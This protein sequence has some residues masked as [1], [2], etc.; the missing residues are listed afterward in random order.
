MQVIRTVKQGY[1]RPPTSSVSTVI[2]AGNVMAVTTQSKQTNNI[3]GLRQGNELY[4]CDPST[5]ELVAYKPYTSRADDMSVV[6]A[7][8]KT[9]RYIIIANFHGLPSEVEVV[10]TYSKEY[11]PAPSD[12]YYDYKNFYKRLSRQHSGL[13]YIVVPEPQKSG[14]WHLHCLF[15]KANNT[16]LYIP[17]QQL[18]AC[19][20]FG[21]VS[22]NHIHTPYGTALYLTSNREK[23]TPERLALYPPR[24]KLYRCSRGIVRP[25]PQK[26]TRSEL[27]TKVTAGG[28]LL[29]YGDCVDI[30]AVS[31]EDGT[32]VRLNR[33][34]HETYE[35]KLKYYD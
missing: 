19:W 24:F 28:Y 4:Y 12:L 2:E 32:T 23:V 30:E 29:K 3:S 25:Q 27:E 13:E 20:G 34:T 8:Y 10:L 15:K 11:D 22:I 14:K 5:G 9:L 6:R 17:Y 26:I 21:G 7:S 1:Q 31:A 18:E 33:I 35:R 16:K